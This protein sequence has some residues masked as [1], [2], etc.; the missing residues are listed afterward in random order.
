ME[1]HDPRVRQWGWLHPRR[2]NVHAVCGG[3]SERSEQA[4]QEP[5]L[6]D[7]QD[8]LR[9]TLDAIQC[10]PTDGFARQHEVSPGRRTRISPCE[11]NYLAREVALA[12]E[13]PPIGLLLCAG[14]DENIL[15]FAAVDQSILVSR[16]VLELPKEDQLKQWLHEAREATEAQRR[17]AASDDEAPS[18]PRKARGLSSRRKRP[19]GR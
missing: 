2:L 7:G 17:Q 1:P 9:H 13:N 15:Q 3:A 8:R 10:V 5:L 18:G 11:L 14:K 16:Y 4:L 19:D 6:A 12:G